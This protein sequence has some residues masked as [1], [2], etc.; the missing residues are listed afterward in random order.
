MHLLSE[1]VFKNKI[2]IVLALLGWMIHN[3]LIPTKQ[4]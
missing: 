4:G 2:K 3:V 1:N